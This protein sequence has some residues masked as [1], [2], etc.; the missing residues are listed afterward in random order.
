MAENEFVFE[1]DE[2]V[3]GTAG[4]GGGAFGPLETGFYD[5]EIVT[6]SLGKTENGNNTL[7]VSIKT[8]TG[9]ELTIYQAFVMDKVWASGK[10]NFGY[11]DWQA[12]AVVTGIKGV[13]SFDKPL[14]KDDGAPVLKNG[15]PV[16]LKAVKEL[17]GVKV[18]L[19]LVKVLDFYKNEVTTDNAI[20]AS[21]TPAGANAKEKLAGDDSRTALE[22]LT[23]RLADK[24]EKR[25]KAYIANGG[26][27]EGTLPEE[28]NTPEAS[29]KDLGL[30]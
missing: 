24:Q 29:A 19:A 18:K 1:L 15:K 27:T 13:T 11:K 6:A 10:E 28:E 2:E 5:C 9:H 30:V 22:K 25:Y 14:L 12:F 8:D 17:E 21:Y 26:S 3:A 16:I 4:N 23:P 7:D 20:F